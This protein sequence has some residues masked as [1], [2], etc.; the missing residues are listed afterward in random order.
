M[1]II[2]LWIGINPY[3]IYFFSVVVFIYINVIVLYILFCFLSLKTILLK[4]NH[5]G[6]FVPA[7]C[8]WLLYNIPQC[9]SILFYLSI[10]LKTVSVI[11]NFLLLQATPLWHVSV[12]MAF[13]PGV[14]VGQSSHAFVLGASRL[15]SKRATLAMLVGAY[16][17]KSSSVFRIWSSKFWRFRE[18]RYSFVISFCISLITSEVGCHLGS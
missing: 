7:H 16:F 14:R 8:F 13:L 6:V 9:A 15:P 18:Y 5:V 3:K 11:T 12:S 10:P 2:C 4:S 1:F 17:L